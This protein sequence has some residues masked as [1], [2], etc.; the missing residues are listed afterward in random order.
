MRR[1]FEL[2]EILK[3]KKDYSEKYKIEEK[4]ETKI[5]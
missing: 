2:S 3:I 4:K 5:E 1:S